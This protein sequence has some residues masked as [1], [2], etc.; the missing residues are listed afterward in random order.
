MA[1]NA[2][3]GIDI[4]L[5]AIKALRCVPG[6]NPGELIANRFDYI[7]FPKMLNQPEV[8]A[9]EQVQEALTQFLSRNSLLGDRV[10]ISVPGQSGLSRFFRPPPVD[11]KTLPDI[12]KYEVK[13]QIPFPIEDVIWDWQRQGGIEVDGRLIDAEVG[14]FAMK[15]DG[16]FR[17]LKPFSDAGIAVDIVQLSPL[18]VYNFACHEIFKK[19]AGKDSD[20]ADPDGGGK[21]V[22][23]MSMG[24]DTTDLIVTNGS[25]LW[26][27][28]IPVG[29]NHF[30]KQLSREMKLTHAKAEQ[31]KRN[32]RQAEDPRQL[33]QAMRPVFNDIVNEVQR[34]ITFFR[35]LDKTAEIG[36]MYLLGNTAQLPGLRQYLGSQLEIDM[37]KIDEFHRLKGP[38]V[39]DQ[40]PFEENLLSFAP[41]YGLCL[42]AANQARLRTNLLPREIQVERIIEAKKPWILSAVSFLMLGAAIG[43]LFASSR[44]YRVSGE[45]TQDG[46]SWNAAITD[47]EDKVKRS[48]KLISDDE[49]QKTRLANVLTVSKELTTSSENK[50][51]WIELYTAIKQSLPVDPRISSDAVDP[52]LVPYA[53]RKVIY[54]NHIESA[55]FPDLAA[56]D[57]RVRPL[58]LNQRLRDSNAAAAAAGPAAPPPGL[59]AAPLGTAAPGTATAAPADST[60]P[61]TGPGWVIEIRAHHFHNSMQALQAQNSDMLYVLDTFIANLLK[62]EIELPGDEAS[63]GGRFRYSDIGVFLPTVVAADDVPKDD[64]VILGNARYTGGGAGGGGGGIQ[65]GGAAGQADDPSSLASGGG[66][67]GGEA[68]FDSSVPPGAY[69]VKRFD[70]CVQFAW[71]PASV[72]E[73]I[74]ARNKRR[75]AEKA[76][77]DAAA[78]AQASQPAAVP[79]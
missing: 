78:A 77:A 60:P 34:S 39:V 53:D 41:A 9:E 54:I 32:L 17:A 36:Q 65:L 64:V 10:A 68:D 67:A 46:K 14:L 21:S 40:G 69:P 16:V 71:K 44:W 31:L 18:A 55:H 12:V 3:W 38:G 48:R 62:G 52:K 28:N 79:Q 25:R 24:T 37:G 47:V 15:R 45:F 30:T 72:S 23:V 22:V 2:V 5:C 1:K 11:Q 7:E 13:Q 66:G 61:L 76:A 57:S 58:F 70:F 74:E 19:T 51:I 43:L 27:R 26:M 50:A 8:N 4:G 20:D 33:L 35:S 42:Q 75:E 6:R 49:E 63:G 73:R 29:G 59:Q 56:W